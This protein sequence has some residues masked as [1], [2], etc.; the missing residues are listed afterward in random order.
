MAAVDRLAAAG[1]HEDVLVVIGHANDFMGHDLTDGEDEI[2]ATIRNQSVHLRRPSIVELA[3]R[4]FQNE[5]CRDFA[6]VS[7]SVRQR[8]T[9]KIPAAWLR[10]CA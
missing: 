1:A 10:T 8:W 2:E 9:R 5:F 7:T 3:F 6:E 4:L